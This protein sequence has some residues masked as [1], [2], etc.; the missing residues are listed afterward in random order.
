MCRFPFLTF[1]LFAALFLANHVSPAYA[2]IGYTGDVEA[3]SPPVLSDP[4]TWTSSTTAYVG[5]TADSSL[6]VDS[7]D[8]NSH[9][10]SGSGDIGFNNGATGTVTVTGTHST[11][12]NSSDLDVG[13][14]GSGNLN[15]AD[16]GA[17]SVGGTTDVAAYGTGTGT[18]NFGTGG[19]TLRRPGRWPHLQVNWRAPA[20]S[21]PAVW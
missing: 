11:W 13:A 15:I 21:M 2:A 19:G 5:N 14:F 6:T 8:S 17:V 3:G 10:L 1:A 16:G 7:T 18:I 20:R 4:N 9:L 12:F